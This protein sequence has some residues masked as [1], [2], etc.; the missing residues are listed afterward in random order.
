MCAQ[1][2]SEQTPETDQHTQN[3]S[4]R[5]S[6]QANS[7][8]RKSPLT[9]A[10]LSKASPFPGIIRADILSFRLLLQRDVGVVRV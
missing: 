8:G 4:R 3:D 2:E 1:T 9:F 10:N 6:G 7:F 5:G